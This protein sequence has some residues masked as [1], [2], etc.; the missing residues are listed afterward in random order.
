MKKRNHS[1]RDLI[2]ILL[3]EQDQYVIS[4][5]I[6]FTEFT[7]SLSDSMNNL[8]LLKHHFEEGDINMHTMFEYVSRDDLKKLAEDDVYG[9]GDFCW[10][11]FEEEESLNELP[12]QVIAELLYLGH[13]KEHLRKPFYNYIRNR[14]VYLAHDDG[15]FNKV[16]YRDFNDFYQML[17]D[18][19]PGKLEQMKVEKS[20]LGLK[21]KKSYPAVPKD[22]LLSLKKLMKE[23]M[24]ISLNNCE[25]TRSRISI[26]LWTIGDFANMDDM[27]EEFEVTSAQNQCEAKL[28]LDKKTK[29]WQIVSC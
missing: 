24:V 8:L 3:N 29:E 22:L 4:Y 18:V 20:L 10:I 7:Y 16:F 23:G 19:I 21:K 17:G 9:Y 2:Y 25:H 11:D 1:I 6:E 14:F 13:T 15:W 5:G 27:Y 12:G 28:I 26:P